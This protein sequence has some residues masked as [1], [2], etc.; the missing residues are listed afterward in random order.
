[1][2]L[3]TDAHCCKPRV[4]MI[5][6]R[7]W[8]QLKTQS[9][10]FP[11]RLLSFKLALI[12]LVCFS[13]FQSQFCHVPSSYPD[14][15]GTNCYCRLMCSLKHSGSFLYY[16]KKTKYQ[17]FP[18]TNNFLYFTSILSDTNSVVHSSPLCIRSPRRRFSFVHRT[19][20]SQPIIVI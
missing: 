2:V 4:L 18:H 19:L 20:L 15:Q 6:G 14:V 17:M 8:V 7:L 10:V 11:K 3:I 5:S 9:Q 12:M 1:M 13:F 16:F